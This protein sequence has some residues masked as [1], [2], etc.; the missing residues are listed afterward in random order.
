MKGKSAKCALKQLVGI[1]WNILYYG[2][3]AKYAFVRRSLAIHSFMNVE[4]TRVVS[5]IIKTAAYVEYTCKKMHFFVQL[6]FF[7]QIADCRKLNC[8]SFRGK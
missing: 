3:I 1:L 2:L 5:Q 7:H 4:K 6:V 8:V